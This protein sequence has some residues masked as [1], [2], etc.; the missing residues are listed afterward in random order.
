[1]RSG[2]RLS[3]PRKLAGVHGIDSTGFQTS[4]PALWLQV[5][6]DAMQVQATLFSTLLQQVPWGVFDR[7]VVAERA[8]RGHRRLSARSHL[9]T[10]LLAQLLPMRGL[11]DIEAITAA[12]AKALGRRRIAPVR[13]ST[14]A[15]ANARRSSGPIEALIPALLSRLSPCQARQT[16]QALRLVDATLIRP[17]FQADPQLSPDSC[18]CRDGA[19]ACCAGWARFQNGNLAAKVHVVFDPTLGVPVFFEV[20]SGNTNDIT[21]AKTAMPIETGATY[22]FDLGYYDFGFWADLDRQACRFV[23]R[24]KKN[25]PI[26][27][28]AEHAVPAGSNVVFDRTVQL[29]SRLA[30]SRTNPFGK[31]GRCIGVR[32]NTGKTITLFSN[33][34]TSPAEEITELYKTRWQIELFFRWLKQHLR[35]RHFFGRS[36]NAVRLQ[37]AAAIVAYLLLKLVHAVART[38]KA[39]HVFVATLRSALF[40][41]LH[42]TELV[43]RIDRLRL[44]PSQPLLERQGTLAL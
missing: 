38:R 42:V 5:E 26:T 27:I 2:P 8:D 40:H 9:A 19:G 41:R 39:A 4:W 7:A 10:L 23:T 36:E 17:G 28:V 34:L 43:E 25:T 18:P 6:T 21:V 35:I 1:P 12:H 30:A 37:I 24:L 16:R 15:D 31:P 20:T 11:R 13:R 32:L 14:F 3:G 22:I 33:D 29:P 44:R